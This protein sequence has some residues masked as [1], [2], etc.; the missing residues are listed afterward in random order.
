MDESAVAAEIVPVTRSTEPITPAR[1][2]FTAVSPGAATAW[3]K[4]V[5]GHETVFRV[6]RSLEDLLPAEALQSEVLGV[7]DHDLNPALGLITVHDTGGDVIGAFRARNGVEEAVAVCVGYGGYVNRRPR[8]LSD[9]L[10]VRAEA[11]SGGLGFEMKTLQAALALGRGFAEIVWT[12]D[13]LRAANARLNVEKLGATSHHY[14]IDRY[15]SQF[16]AGLYGGLPTDRLHM[17]WE[18]AAP[19]VHARLLGRIAPLT[20]TDVD[21]LLHFDPQRIDAERVLV[22]IPSDVDALLAR[23][24][25]AA[26]RWRLTLRET[27]QRAF[28]AGYVITGFVRDTLPEQQ[29]S[30]YVLSKR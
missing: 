30:S 18:I 25:N 2:G 19:T 24:P 15:G 4:R 26:L 23:D 6:L 14:D 11:R 8:L 28:A 20:P 21:D 27:L 13:P 10:V 1:L 22:H 17:T 5:A 29:L 7:T 16:G 3:T 9:L 12:V